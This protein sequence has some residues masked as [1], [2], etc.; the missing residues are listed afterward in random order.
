MK[1]WLKNKMM[2]FALA[3][4]N[5]E[6]NSLSLEGF[7]PSENSNITRRHNQHSVMDALLQGEVTQEVEQLRWRMYKTL[8]ANT[9]IDSKIIGY[10]DDGFP[11]VESIKK[12][13][14]KLLHNIKNYDKE[15]EYDLII[16]F[17]NETE[18]TLGFSDTLDL[19]KVD[20]NNTEIKKFNYDYDF[21]INVEREF[22]PKYKIEK[23][24][25][26]L[27]IKKHKTTENHLLEFYLPKNLDIY[28]KTQNLIISN[29]NKNKINNPNLEFNS[30]ELITDK[31][32]VGSKQY[33]HYKFDNISFNMVKEYNGYLII[34]Y[35]ANILI[36]GE[37]I[38][39]KYRKKDL[40]MKY[41][42]KESR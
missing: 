2:T 22:L 25:E 11:I 41:D 32:T 23:L 27:H 17:N 8:E 33:L 21:K 4:S 16:S 26:K 39:E 29:I 28:D 35:N 30:V 12:D 18:G 14:Q 3:I 13:N 36:D 7:T 15:E 6:K 1:N 9:I 31:N 38:F 37:F 19:T 5:V 20:E 10:D 34:K 24:C 40:D 42:N